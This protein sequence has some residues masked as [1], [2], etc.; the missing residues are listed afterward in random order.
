MTM[1]C[2]YAVLNGLSN[3]PPSEPPQPQS[4]EGYYRRP[5]HTDYGSTDRLQAL[6]DGYFGLN[7]V[8]LANFVTAFILNAMFRLG[9][10]GQNDVPMLIAAV[11]VLFAIFAFATYP[12][13]RKIGL[14]KGWSPTSPVVASILMGLNSALCCGIIGYV[15]MQQIAFKEMQ[16]YGLKGSFPGLRKRDV[17]AKIAELRAIGNAPPFPPQTSG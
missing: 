13:N 9:V 11:L 14:G 15:V 2:E 17:V 3:L 16:K 10:L 7:W 1:I 6:A 5:G 12:F 8:F 4:F